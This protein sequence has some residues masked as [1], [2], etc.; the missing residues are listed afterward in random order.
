[1]VKI[2][3]TRLAII[4]WFVSVMLIF[5]STLLYDPTAVIYQQPQI[6]VATYYLGLAFGAFGGI[7]LFWG[8][9]QRRRVV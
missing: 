2:T 9:V 7:L 8:L 4:F 1:M 3:M 6:Q 5:A